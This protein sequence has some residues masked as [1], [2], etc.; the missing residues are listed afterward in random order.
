MK[1]TNAR[2]KQIIKEELDNVLN[3]VKAASIKSGRISYASQAGVYDVSMS[4]ST[5]K[6]RTNL[7]GAPEEV[8][9]YIQLR[10]PNL[11]LD[12]LRNVAYNIARVAKRDS[13]VNIREDEILAALESGSITLP[14]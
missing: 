12:D 10:V 14:R 7:Y 5:G 11:Q 6:T 9:D 3:E 4:I 2:L 13:Y 1:I 8:T